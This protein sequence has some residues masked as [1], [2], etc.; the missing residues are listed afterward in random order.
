MSVTAPVAAAE[1][2]RYTVTLD[3]ALGT[4][5]VEVRPSAAVRVLAS[6]SPEAATRLV[7]DSLRGVGLLAGELRLEPASP[8]LRY[9]ANIRPTPSRH[10]GLD[11]RTDAPLTLSDPRQWLWL[12][13]GFAGDDT[14][15]VEFVLPPKIAVASPWPAHAMGGFMLRPQMLD[16]QGLVA[17]GALAQRELKAGRATLRLSL[18]S[19]DPLEVERFGA[20]AERVWRS[21]RTAVAAPPGSIEQLLVVP[22][23]GVREA[24]PWGEV[25]RGTGNS[26][27]ALVQRD[28]DALALEEDWTLYHELSHLYLPFVGGDRWLSEGFASYYQNVLR[29]RAGVLAPEVAWQRLAEGLARGAQSAKPGQTV[30]EGGRM[31]TY[32]TGAALALEWDIALRHASGGK[33]SL[34]TA[35]ARFAAAE[36]PAAETWDAMR[37]ARASPE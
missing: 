1:L 19:R 9:A 35:L 20:W 7:Q 16:A 34:D 26:V 17:F 2:A 10:D 29:A 3:A 33:V 23:G 14:L 24:V 5:T 11:A 32:W 22:I 31:V 28:A 13:A 15:R 6:W 4:A 37:V 30:E 25:R 12:P 36:L 27:L 21:T 18:A 8:S